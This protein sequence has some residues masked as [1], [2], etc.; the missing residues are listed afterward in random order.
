MSTK[1]NGAETAEDDLVEELLNRF[2]ST[3]PPALPPLDVESAVLAREF[4]EVFG[5]IG[6]ANDPLSPAESVKNRLMEAVRAEEPVSSSEAAP[7]DVVKMPASRWPNWALPMAASVAL[8][9]LGVSGWQFARL[10]AQGAT[11]ESLAEQ[12]S[13][14]NVELVEVATGF[15]N[16]LG[17]MQNQLA[18]VT[19]QGVEV[20]KLYP[21]VADV[22]KTGARGALF[23]ASDRQHWYLRIDDLEPC[24][25]GRTYQLW[26]VRGDGTSVDGGILDVKHGIELEVTSDSM[27][28]GTIAVHVTLEP[29]G[30]SQ[31]PS[32]PTVLYGDEV[33][34]IL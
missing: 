14:K 27:P 33:M 9:L 22:A 8:A 25:Q 7:G 31:E 16:E 23:V 29:A 3:V 24:P 21:Q 20:C 4:T 12:L 15:D 26:F 18:L 10:D 32:G 6:Y 1:E 11:I 5:L 13:V 19:S 17:R 34:R 2:S 30:G 28:D